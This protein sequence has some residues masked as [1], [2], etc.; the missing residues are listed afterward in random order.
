M[1][2]LSILVPELAFRAAGLF[3][4]V[5]ALWNVVNPLDP[6]IER[7]LFVGLL[8]VI[9]YLQSLMNP[10]RSPLL[11]SVD[12][13]LILGTVASY[14]YVIWNADVMED[15]SLFMPTE[16]L[17]LGFVAIVTILEATRRSMGWALTVLV[18]AFIVYI[19]FGENLPGWLGG[20]VGFGGERIMGNLY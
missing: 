11:R 7:P 13:V 18:A 17:V 1:A 4:T 9:V 2:R 6:L 14:G 8:V 20:H 10:G 16:A 19:Y 15:L 5:F 3:L 12:L